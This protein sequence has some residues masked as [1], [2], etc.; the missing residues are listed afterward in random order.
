[1]QFSVISKTII[2]G[3]LINAIWRIISGG[4][5][6]SLKIIIIEVIKPIIAVMR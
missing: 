1:M 4:Y 5:L 2:F 3:R 6:N